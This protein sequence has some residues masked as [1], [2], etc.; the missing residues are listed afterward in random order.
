[1]G[2]KNDSDHTVIQRNE[3]TQA[4]NEWWVKVKLTILRVY[5]HSLFIIFVIS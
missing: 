1:M 2:K 4:S 5:I 3:E